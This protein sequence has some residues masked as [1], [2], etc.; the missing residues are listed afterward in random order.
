MSSLSFGSKRGT[1]TYSRDSIN[2]NVLTASRVNSTTCYQDRRPLYLN[3]W[4]KCLPFNAT[5]VFH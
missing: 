5:V 2:D 4:N 3:D 1:L